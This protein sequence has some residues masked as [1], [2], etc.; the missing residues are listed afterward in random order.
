M[1]PSC[2]QWRVRPPRV[3]KNVIT[4]GRRSGSKGW[5][6][7]QTVVLVDEGLHDLPS[8]VFESWL[9]SHRWELFSL[10]CS[11][12]RGDNVT[13]R[14]TAAFECERVPI[15]WSSF[16]KSCKRT[17]KF[18]A[19]ERWC[20][21]LSASC[22]TDQEKMTVAEQAPTQQQ[23]KTKKTQCSVQVLVL[24]VEDLAFI[25][26]SSENDS[27]DKRKWSQSTLW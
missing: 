3:V 4:S 12:A 14:Q 21:N 24:Q 9:C 2:L 16:F 18:E 20:V 15:S 27:V 1:R 19:L 7:L 5:N 10:T 22:R 13:K 6:S 17:S 25:M 26:R 23:K 11:V 8:H